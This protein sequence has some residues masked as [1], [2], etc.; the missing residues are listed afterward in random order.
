[1][2]KFAKLYEE[3]YKGGLKPAEQLALTHMYNRLCL[4]DGN[5]D[6]YDKD[7]HAYYITFS[8]TELA[9]LLNVSENTVT[10]IFSE[11]VRKGW[12]IIKRR[13]NSTN[14]IF[15]PKS[16]NSKNCETKTQKLDYKKTEHIN[17]NNKYTN[18]NKINTSVKKSSSSNSTNENSAID[19]LAAA[20]T[21]KSGIS[22]KAVAVMKEM[23]AG[24]SNV[25]YNYAQMFFLAKKRAFE[26][27]PAVSSDM[28]SLERNKHI[29]KQLESSISAIVR[30]A[31]ADNV[32]LNAYLFASFRDLVESAVNHFHRDICGQNIPSNKP[33]AVKPDIPLFKIA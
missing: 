27:N 31:N 8:R 33:K 2:S 24:N 26:N 1:M 28:L 7:N 6:F 21:I 12:I 14:R 15:L 29:N 11:L 18:T 25:L 22:P 4:S 13:F 3:F 16:L 23:A 9:A 32:N 30:G 17:T 10:K 20:L 19:K 5:N